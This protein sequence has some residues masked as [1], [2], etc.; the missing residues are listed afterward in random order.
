MHVEAVAGQE[1]LFVV[2]EALELTVQVG[3]TL[4]LLPWGGDAE[5]VTTEGLRWKLEGATLPFGTTRGIS[6]EAERETVRISLE[7]GLLLVSHHR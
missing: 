2:D 4:S 1:H 6:N 7:S 3:D 5:G